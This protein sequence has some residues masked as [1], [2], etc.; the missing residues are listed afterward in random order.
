MSLLCELMSE[1]QSCRCER[2]LDYL[3]DRRR[4]T[5]RAEEAPSVGDVTAL[6]TECL[7]EAGGSCT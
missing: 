1:V 4:E 5:F 7:S 2:G 3:E 6:A